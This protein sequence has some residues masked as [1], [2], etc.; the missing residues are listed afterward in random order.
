MYDTGRSRTPRKENIGPHLKILYVYLRP[1]RSHQV[2]EI[3][4]KVTMNEKKQY[5]KIVSH[6]ILDLTDYKSLNMGSCV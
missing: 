4:Y 3:R 2:N 6:K 1:P 5:M